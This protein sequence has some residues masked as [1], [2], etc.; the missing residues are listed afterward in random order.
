MQKNSCP[1]VFTM[2]ITL[3]LL[4]SIYICKPELAIYNLQNYHVCNIH[5]NLSLYMILLV[6]WHNRPTLFHPKGYKAHCNI[7]DLPLGRVTKANRIE[8]A[9][10]SIYLSCRGFSWDSFSYIFSLISLIELVRWW[11]ARTNTCNSL[12]TLTMWTIW[13]IDK[14]IAVWTS[15]IYMYK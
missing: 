14:Y 15:Y 7:A 9:M 10:A 12:Y 4:S 11:C 1:H 3:V 8:S 6:L 2:K 5:I 13:C